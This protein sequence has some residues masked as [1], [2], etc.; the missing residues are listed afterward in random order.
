MHGKLGILA[1]Q[2]RTMDVNAKVLVDSGICILAND[3]SFWPDVEAKD[4]AKRAA[5]KWRS[6]I[7]SDK[8]IPPEDV[9]MPGAA[10]R[11]SKHVPFRG[12]QADSDQGHKNS[13]QHRRRK[14]SQGL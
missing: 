9:I 12:M 3:S 14:K 8:S 6:M 13:N 7:F 10:R 2:L 11:A 1:E 5:D 4:W